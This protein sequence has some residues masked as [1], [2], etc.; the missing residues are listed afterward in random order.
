M[1]AEL[2]PRGQ[3][4]DPIN[5]KLVGLAYYWSWDQHVGNG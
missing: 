1:N 5:S 3:R 2:V 4:Y